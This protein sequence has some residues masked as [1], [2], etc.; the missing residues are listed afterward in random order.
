MSCRV[1]SDYTKKKGAS[2]NVLQSMRLPG[3]G[4]CEVLHAMRLPV[5]DCR[6]SSSG[7]ES[8]RP[9]RPG[10]GRPRG[11]SGLSPDPRGP[12]SGSGGT[13]S[14]SPRTPGARTIFCPRGG[15]SSR[16]RGRDSS[17]TREGDSSRTRE[18]DSSGSSGFRT[19]SRA[20]RIYSTSPGIFSTSPGIYSAS[21]GIYSASP[22]IYSAS[23]GIYS[24]SPDVSFPRV[25]C[26]RSRQRSFER[27]RDGL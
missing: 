13:R 21:P 23:P 8:S 9:R 20:T 16:P 22:G 19:Q 17:R 18:G 15:D 3:A 7:G 26:I 24:A 5:P 14:R 1:E 27:P 2:A 6:G 11:C 25:S 4:Q 10:R 12:R